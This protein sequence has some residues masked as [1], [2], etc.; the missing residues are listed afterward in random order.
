MVK[1][2]LRCSVDN[3]LRLLA[4]LP[5]H[6]QGKMCRARA[7]HKQKHKATTQKW[8]SGGSGEWGEKQ[9]SADLPLSIDLYAGVAT[10]CVAVVLGDADV[11]LSSHTVW[12]VAAALSISDA[13][14]FTRVA[15]VTTGRAG[16]V[17]ESISLTFP[18]SALD[19]DT[20]VSL[21]FGGVGSLLVPV[22]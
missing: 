12:A 15:V 14:V 2:W 22:T 8:C 4:C 13:D 17:G 11:L 19:R 18:S 6:V 16:L 10:V 3:T 7:R 5:S 21:D 9:D 1:K 20:L